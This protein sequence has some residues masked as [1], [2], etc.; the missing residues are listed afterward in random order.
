MNYTSKRKLDLLNHATVG[1][2]IPCLLNPK[3]MKQSHNN[4]HR[5]LDLVLLEELDQAQVLQNI[6]VLLVED[7][8]D[9]AGLLILILKGAGAEVITA[10]TASEALTLLTSHAPHVLLCNV[11]LPDHNGDWLIQQ[12]REQEAQTGQ[13]LPALAVT[14]YTR[15]CSSKDLLSKGFQGYLDKFFAPEQLVIEVLALVN[16]NRRH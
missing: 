9:I 14:S 8:P 4:L 13:F 15:E 2:L 10:V 1:A 12:I 3:P 7:E 16:E 11:L 5:Q 6:Q